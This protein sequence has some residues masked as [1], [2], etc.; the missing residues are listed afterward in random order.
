[1]GGTRGDGG[2]VMSERRRLQEELEGERAYCTECGKECKIIVV[3]DG[4]GPYEFWGQKCCQN[5]YVE[6]SACCE[7]ELSDTPPDNED[8]FE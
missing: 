5:I 7:A 3:D 6:R 4:I 2:G 1:M 8:E